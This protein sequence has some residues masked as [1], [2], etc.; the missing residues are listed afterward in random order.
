MLLN[1]CITYTLLTVYIDKMSIK[2]NVT[3][4]NYNKHLKFSY[5]T[6]LGQA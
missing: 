4:T 6:S 1:T 2:R 5:R 3:G